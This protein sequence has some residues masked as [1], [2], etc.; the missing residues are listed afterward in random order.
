MSIDHGVLMALQE[1]E[2]QL[3][4]AQRVA[5]VG[6]WEWDM[7]RD[8]ITWS[9][10]L[11]RIFGLQVQEL[12]PSYE[13]YLSHVHPHDRDELAASV[14]RAMQLRERLETVY[15]VITP[16]GAAKWVRSLGE[17]TVDGDGNPV[18]LFAT[19]QDVT[20]EMAA[21]ERRYSRVR[22]ESGAAGCDAAP[23]AER[24]PAAT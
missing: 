4:E 24:T 5:R 7:T 18:R 16:A 20:G 17:V 15:R 19:A 11:Y 23:S 14:E 12:T 3:A 9:D 2:Q 10:E 8:R 13:E 1:R 21:L 6:S 22:A